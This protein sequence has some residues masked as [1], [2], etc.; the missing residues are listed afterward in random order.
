VS[1]SS[2]LPAARVTATRVVIV[3][4]EL[5]QDGETSAFALLFRKHASEEFCRKLPGPSHAS[6]HLDIEC[7]TELQARK[8]TFCFI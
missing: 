3:V 4:A 8:N 6:Q 1:S 2:S 7:H 5:K